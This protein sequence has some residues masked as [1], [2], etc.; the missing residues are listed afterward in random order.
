MWV[1]RLFIYAAEPTNFIYQLVKTYRPGA[2]DTSLVS[3]DY[4]NNPR[5]M[6][7]VYHLGPRL[8]VA[9]R[10]GKETLSGGE[11]NNKQFNDFLVGDRAHAVFRQARTSGR[12]AS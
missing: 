8:G 1:D 4:I 7:A 5:T 9:K 2:I 10:L 6:N 11:L 3:T 12:R